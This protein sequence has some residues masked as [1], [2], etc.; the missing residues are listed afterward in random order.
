MTYYWGDEAKDDDKDGTRGI[1][2]SDRKCS[3]ALN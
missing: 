3:R 2:G 1:H